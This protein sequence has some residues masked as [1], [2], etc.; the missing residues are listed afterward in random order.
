MPAAKESLLRELDA[1]CRDLAI[2]GTL[3]CNRHWRSAGRALARLEKGL[4]RPI[5]LAVFGEDRAGKSSLINFLLKRQALPSGGLAGQ[6]AYLLVHYASEPVMYAVGQDGSKTRL[7]SKAVTRIATPEPDAPAPIANVIYSATDNATPASQPPAPRLGSARSGHAEAGKLIELG[8]PHDLL[9]SVEMIEARTFPADGASPAIAKV[10]R[11]VDIAI[12]C[13]LATQAWKESERAEWTN[14]PAGRRRN[15]LLLVTYKDAI[16]NQNDEMKILTRLRHNTARLFSDVVLISLR[17]ALNSEAGMDEDAANALRA[18]SNGEAVE[19]AVSALAHHWH[20]QRL[21]RAARQLQ[22]IAGALHRGADGLAGG[23]TDDFVTRLEKAAA[24]H[25]AA[26]SIFPSG[27]EGGEAHG[28][29][30]EL[31][32]AG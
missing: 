19:T 29:R 20:Q 2:A 24:D 11:A 30:S 32:P 28:R 27:E 26:C 22:L 3:N 25:G 15:A 31:L 8:L 16:R 4:S 14:I 17:D 12:W 10:F 5:R 21:R 9:R 1:I 23:M 6:A 18:R 7:T 13:T